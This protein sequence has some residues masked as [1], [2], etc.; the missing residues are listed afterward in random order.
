[1]DQLLV[2]E[3]VDAGALAVLDLE[4]FQVPDALVGVGHVAQ[5]LVGVDQHQAGPVD[6]EQLVGALDDPAQ[7]VVEVPGGVA[8]VAEVAQGL[9]DLVG[10]H[11]HRQPPPRIELA[12]PLSRSGSHACRSS[13]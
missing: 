2:V 7:G 1:V 4:L 10:G 3:G 9:A 11:R 6:G 8:Q 12:Y 5:E 13:E